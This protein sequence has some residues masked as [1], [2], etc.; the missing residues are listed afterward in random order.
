MDFMKTLTEAMDPV[1]MIEQTQKNVS[2]MLNFV[3]PKELNWALTKLVEANA[4]YAKSG[5]EVVK[6]MTEIVK[7]TT[8]K[9]TKSF[10][11]K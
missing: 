2:T 5:V 3:Q 1:K 10:D 8:T 11:T 6:S 7:D 9:F 4:A